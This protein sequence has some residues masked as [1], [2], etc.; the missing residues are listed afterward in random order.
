MEQKPI[1]SQRFPG[2]LRLYEET[3]STN[4]DAR[5]WLLSGAQHGDMIIALRQSG[6]RGRLGR[7]FISPKGGLYMS[8]ILKTSAAP[9]AVTTLCAVAV[10]KAIRQLTGIETDIKWVNDL[11]LESKKICGIL[12]ENVFSGS[13][14]LGMIAGIG[15]NVFGNAFPKELHPIA[16]SLYPVAASSPI[17]METLAEVI[18][19][20][21]LSGLDQI[22]AHIDAYRRHCIT[23]NKDVFWT[24]NGQTLTGR[25][26][27]TTEDGAL[28]IRLPDGKMHTVAFGE[29][30]IRP[31]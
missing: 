28:I 29:V 7:S 10:H 12:C 1:P 21:I 14:S 9:G 20:E 25:A 18:R 13:Q 26:L 3:V 11:L 27:D 5:A 19:E 17:S 24:E 30:S 8:L 16:R 31:I 6:G 4:R 23:L 22:P 2:D 15:V